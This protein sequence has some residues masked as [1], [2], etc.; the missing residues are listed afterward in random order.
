MYKSHIRKHFVE[1]S[2]TNATRGICLHD[3]HD[4]DPQDLWSLI[5]LGRLK[6]KHEI[7]VYSEM[8]FSNI[9]ITQK[10]EHL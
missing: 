10:I 2:I 9:Q 6:Q 7:C 4:H 8:C 5:V 3:H 1:P